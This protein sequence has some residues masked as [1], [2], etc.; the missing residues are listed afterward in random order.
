[1]RFRRDKEPKKCTTVLFVQSPETIAE[2]KGDDGGFYCSEF[3][4]DAGETIEPVA[5]SQPPE[6]ASTAGASYDR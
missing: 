6:M 1:M 4:A 2:W 3:C 5:A